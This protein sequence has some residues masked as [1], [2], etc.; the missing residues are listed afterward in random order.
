MTTQDII[1]STPMNSIP[2]LKDFLVCAAT[3]PITPSTPAPPKRSVPKQGYMQA[4]FEEQEK[5][6]KDPL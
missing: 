5:A 3:I 6:K 4:M 2:P 1:T